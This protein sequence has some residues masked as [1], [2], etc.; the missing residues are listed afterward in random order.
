MLRK[1]FVCCSITLVFLVTG[2]TQ[3]IAQ[4]GTRTIIAKPAS[5][6]LKVEG[7][8]VTLYAH[9][10]LARAFCF[11]DGKDGLIFQYNEVRNRCSDIDFN[12]YNAGNFTVGIEGGRIGSLVDLGSAEDLKLRYGYL[13]EATIGNGEGFASLRLENGKMQIL[14]ERKSQTVQ[15]LKESALVFQAGKSGA[16]A[17]IKLGHIYLARI[18]D[19]HEKDFQ[20]L[21]KLIVIAYTPNESVT[22]RWQVL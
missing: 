12:T 6:E 2:A 7:G 10:P 17:P 11:R 8:V 13:R 22:I 4:E 16:T 19:S 15:E 14:K 3:L 21:V 18:T 9:D 20:T 1:G 5:S